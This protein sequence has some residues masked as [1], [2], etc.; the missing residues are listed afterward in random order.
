MDNDFVLIFAYILLVWVS[1]LLIIII[2][3]GLFVSIG[4]ICKETYFFIKKNIKKI[5]IFNEKN[6]ELILIK[7]EN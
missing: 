3:F 1:I 4:C 5:F 2:L 6:H 7:I